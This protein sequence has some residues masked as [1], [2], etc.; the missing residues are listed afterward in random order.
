[1]MDTI[2]YGVVSDAGALMNESDA[3]WLLILVVLWVMMCLGVA[4][5]VGG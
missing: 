3:D 2:R 5:L 1:M 4:W